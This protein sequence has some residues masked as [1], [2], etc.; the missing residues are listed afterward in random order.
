MAVVYSKARAFAQFHGGSAEN[1]HS[2]DIAARVAR[3]SQHGDRAPSRPVGDALETSLLGDVRVFSPCGVCE[4]PFT[5]TAPSRGV[6]GGG[7]TAGAVPDCEGPD[8]DGGR[9]R[10]S[11]PMTQDWSA[12]TGVADGC[13]TGNVLGASD[14][15]PAT[16]SSP[17][18][19]AARPLPRKQKFQALPL[20]LQVAETGFLFIDGWKL[21]S[22]IC[23]PGEQWRA[24]ISLMAMRRRGSGGSSSSSIL[25]LCRVYRDARREAKIVL[26]GFEFCSLF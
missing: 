20:G 17:A 25:V 22:P 3:K 12:V 23:T 1:F 8:A 16:S 9:A 7:V 15:T 19:A 11:S 13:V 24:T 18:D 2:L 10:W 21:Y 6:N 4:A 14:D 26:K 5:G